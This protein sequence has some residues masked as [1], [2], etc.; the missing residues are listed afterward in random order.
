MQR[1]KVRIISLFMQR[2]EK[3][4]RD[5]TVVRQGNDASFFY[6]VLTGTL[7]V[8]KYSEAGDRINLVQL[9]EGD[10]FGEMYIIYVI[11]LSGLF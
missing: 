4:G 9:K 6:L 7:S 8:H 2:Y 11:I 1:N 3:V 5:R 10:A